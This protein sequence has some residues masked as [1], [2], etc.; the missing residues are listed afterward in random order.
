M[1]APPQALVEAGR[2]LKRQ[3]E[4]CNERLGADWRTS[5]PANWRQR[6]ADAGA[7]QA[8]LEAMLRDNQVMRRKLDD[9]IELQQRAGADWRVA[10]PPD[11]RARLTEHEGLHRERYELLRMVNGARDQLAAGGG[12]AGAGALSPQA[13]LHAVIKDGQ[14]A[15]R[16]LAELNSEM[17]HRLGADWRAAL[18]LDWRQ[19]LAGADALQLQLAA[20]L[21]EV[22]ALRVQ[23][24]ELDALKARLGE[25]WEVNFARVE[26]FRAQLGARWQD[27]LDELLRA[28]DAMKRQQIREGRGGG[29][30]RGAALQVSLSMPSMLA[31]G[32]PAAALALQL[33][34]AASAGASAESSCVSLPPIHSPRQPPRTAG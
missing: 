30:A 12:A 28:I 10:L 13:A 23:A 20:L 27:R 5:L 7:L 15:R 32:V 14:S 29:R 22:R 16:Q 31:G 1:L 9:A 33:Q 18:P 2:A 34:R 21:R 17:L 24:A 25:G 6:L 26:A 3:Q 8:Q 11:W 4:E 19:R